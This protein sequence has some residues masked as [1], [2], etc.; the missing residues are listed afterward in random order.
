MNDFDWIRDCNPFR[1]FG[2]DADD[3]GKWARHLSYRQKKNLIKND[4]VLV[5]TEKN[6]DACGNGFHHE[7]IRGYRIEMV[8]TTKELWEEYGNSIYPSLYPYTNN[9]LFYD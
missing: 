4:K 8:Y 9:I 5:I 2:F 6:G 7:W 1:P 3:A